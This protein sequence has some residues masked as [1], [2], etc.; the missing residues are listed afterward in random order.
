MSCGR[1]FFWT[2]WRAEDLDWKNVM[3]DSQELICLRCFSNKA[4][5][6][7]LWVVWTPL[8]VAISHVI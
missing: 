3:G 4:A 1:K 2:I 6:L 8:V 7:G 5:E